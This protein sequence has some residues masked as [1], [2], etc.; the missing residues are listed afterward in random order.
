MKVCI[1]VTIEA[2]RDPP[3]SKHA[4]MLGAIGHQVLVVHPIS[5]SD[6]T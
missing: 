5:D 4:E 6:W 1:F 2:T 3:V